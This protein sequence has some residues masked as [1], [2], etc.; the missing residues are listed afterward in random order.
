LEAIAAFETD[1]PHR[2]GKLLSLMMRN[3][4][5]NS[6]IIGWELMFTDGLQKYQCV[7]VIEHPFDAG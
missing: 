1:T 6:G 3:T 4:G 7:T 2:P 5:N